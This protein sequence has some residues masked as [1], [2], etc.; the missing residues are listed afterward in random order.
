VEF[1]LTAKPT[2]N[3]LIN[4]GIAYVDAYYD[5]YKGAQCYPGQT[6]ATGCIGGSQDLTDEE[7][8]NAPKWKMSLQGR[9]DI[10]LDASFNAFLSAT[11]RWQDDSFVELNHNPESI[12]DSY[13]VLD[14]TAGLESDDGRWSAHYF[15]K[16]ALDDFYADY[17]FYTTLN[18]GNAHYLTR[19]AWRYMGVEFTYN[20]G[21]L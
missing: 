15:V 14:L 6:E 20:F 17:P 7:I 19:D 16:N 2:D 8:A 3:L 10:E 5:D 1:E 4:G 11:Y 9:Y 13:G 21:A 18:G 12:R